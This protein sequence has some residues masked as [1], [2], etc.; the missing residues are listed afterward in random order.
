MRNLNF[1]QG[2]NGVVCVIYSVHDSKC[3]WCT[4]SL[5]KSFNNTLCQILSGFSN[6]QR[7]GD[8]LRPRSRRATRP[9]LRGPPVES[10]AGQVPV[11]PDLRRRRPR[12][13]P[14]P[15]PHVDGRRVVLRLQHFPSG[16]F[17]LLTFKLGHELVSDDVIAIALRFEPGRCPD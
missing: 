13:R 17:C 6:H 8:D 1:K 3:G 4:L 14:F 9:R 11:G 12:R 16:L 5:N 7:P 10:A 2:F 15:L